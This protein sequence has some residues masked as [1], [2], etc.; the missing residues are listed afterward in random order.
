[1]SATTAPA[2]ASTEN[3]NL[4][5]MSNDWFTVT[6]YDIDSKKDLPNGAL[7]LPND[8]QFEIHIKPTSKFVG[9]HT[10]CKYTTQ[11]NGNGR[12]KPYS[13]KTSG[14]TVQ[15]SVG[16]P[17]KKLYD[18]DMAITI[19]L[20]AGNGN[21]SVT[22]DVMI[23]TPASAMEKLNERVTAT[24]TEITLAE[25]TVLP[26]PG[27]NRVSHRKWRVRNGDRSFTVCKACH[28]NCPAF[29][30]LLK[31][32]ADA[33]K[34][35]V[36]YEET[37]D[38]I[39]ACTC[40]CPC[41]GKAEWP[42]GNLFVSIR[43]QKTQT[44]CQRSPTNISHCVVSNGTVYEVCIKLNENTTENRDNYG[45]I[46]EIDGVKSDLLYY[47][48]TVHAQGGLFVKH[49]GGGQSLTKGNKDVCVKVHQYETT[50][51]NTIDMTALIL[52]RT[53][54]TLVFTLVSS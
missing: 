35:E 38:T 34:Q 53:P 6:V 19:V 52:K 3:T 11:V 48:N 43:E 22:F 5:N 30:K 29:A 41:S 7:V 17:F 16:M 25:T 27:K 39:V 4:V 2:T 1:M 42:V 18:E 44:Y 23:T 20:T 37:H 47:N 50:H 26:C 36:V 15:R 14:I 10:D 51:D 33:E 8:T 31:Q 49:V 28:L 24:E 13:G 21:K 40:D 54:L 12:P 45:A 46:V 9:A 32:Q